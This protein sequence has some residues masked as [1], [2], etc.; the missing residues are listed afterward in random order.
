[1]LLM[2]CQ[3]SHLIIDLIHQCIAKLCGEVVHGTLADP[4]VTCCAANSSCSLFATKLEESNHDLQFDRSSELL[5]MKTVA[6]TNKVDKLL[7]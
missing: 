6:L 3:P 2:G 1:M 5:D 4:K 7:K